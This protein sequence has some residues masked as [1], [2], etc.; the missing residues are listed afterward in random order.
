MCYAFSAASARL[1]LLRFLHKP[2]NLENPFVVCEQKKAQYYHVNIKRLNAQSTGVSYS[3]QKIT[4][5]RQAEKKPKREEIRI[6]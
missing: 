5:V 1:A 4:R 3:V 6:G 2:S